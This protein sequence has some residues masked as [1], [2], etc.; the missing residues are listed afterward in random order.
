MRV[1]EITGTIMRVQLGRLDLI[2]EGLRARKSIFREKLA[3]QSLAKV[4]V[5]ACADGDSGSSLHLLFPDP[6]VAMRLS[7]GL[8]QQGMLFAPVTTRPAHACWKWTPL[9]G[10]RAHWHSAANPFKLTARPYQY[11]TTE[12]L[13]S[14]GILM[15]TAKMEIDLNCSLDETVRLAELLSQTLSH[16]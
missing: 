12:Y 3:R 10:D 4:I 5:G 11:P 2:L 14:V 15:R 1:S 16:T 6:E 8:R 9:L 7:K 13:E